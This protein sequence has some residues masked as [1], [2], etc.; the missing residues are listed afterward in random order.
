MKAS[1]RIRVAPAASA[2]TR[3]SSDVFGIEVVDFTRDLKVRDVSLRQEFSVQAGSRHLFETGFEVHA[4]RTGWGWTVGA[5]MTAP[6]SAA[7]R[8]AVT[9]DPG[10]TSPRIGV[11]LPLLLR[12]TRDT[13]RAAVWF[14]DRY[15]PRAGV[16]L[17]PG[18]RIDRSGLAGETI[19]SPRLGIRLDLTPRTR[20]RFAIGRYTQS[21]GY[22]K[23]LQSDYFFDLTSADSGQLK[24]ERSVHVIGA[25]ERALTSSVTA[26]V[27]A[28]VKTFDRLI[29]GRLETP[30]ETAARVAPYAFPAEIASSVPSAPIITTNPMN[31][32]TGRA[33]GFDVYV[34]KPPQSR[35][36]RLSGWASY[37]FG[38]A[39]ITSYGRQYPFNYD[40]RHSLSVVGPYWL[41]RRLDVGATL[42]VASGFPTTPA[43]GVR[44]M[45]TPGADGSL[46]PLKSPTGAVRLDR[47]SGRRWESQHGTVAGLRAARPARHVQSQERDRPVAD[48]RGNIQRPESQARQHD[49]L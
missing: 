14:Q 3:T 33:Y 9:G 5:D 27:E 16:L 45:A 38:V 4:L 6:L 42:R 48:L 1:D 22:E 23:L 20:L 17:E 40:R 13:T 44:V 31:G 30:A 2:M 19:A 26:R 32:A 18:L 43:V 34:E 11:G 47:R 15:Q 12:S 21:P 24:S 39:D 25:I 35:R 10:P 46:V 29:V 7:M 36:D 28:Y 41:S 37:T 8:F 49:L